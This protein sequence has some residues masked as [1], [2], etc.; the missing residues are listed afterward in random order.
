MMLPDLS[1]LYWM[2][3]FDEQQPEAESLLPSRELL[4][5]VSTFLTQ[6]EDTL[7]TTMRLTSSTPM[8]LES[9]SSEDTLLIT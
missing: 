1:S 9:T 3:D 8:S 2:L 5:E 6:S 4:M 7:D